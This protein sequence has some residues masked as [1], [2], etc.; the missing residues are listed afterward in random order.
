[1]TDAVKILHLQATQP[2]VGSRNSFTVWRQK[3]QTSPW[4]LTA[5]SIGVFTS[6]SQKIV[7]KKSLNLSLVALFKNQKS[8]LKS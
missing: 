1:M 7:S 3:G 4:L 6:E 8:V 5:S 2:S